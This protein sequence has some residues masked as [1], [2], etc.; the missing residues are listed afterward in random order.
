MAGSLSAHVCI[1]GNLRE[2]WPLAFP[3]P[4]LVLPLPPE[5]AVSTRHRRRSAFPCLPVENFLT[6]RA[7]R[8]PAEK[9][10]AKSYANIRQ[11]RDASRELSS[12][13]K[14]KKK[15]E[16]VSQWRAARRCCLSCVV[17]SHG[18]G[19]SRCS[20]LARCAFA[21][22]ACATMKTNAHVENVK[23]ESQVRRAS[24]VLVPRTTDGCYG[25]VERAV[26]IF[27]SALISPTCIFQRVFE[28]K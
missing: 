13:M 19:K 20:H 2:R 14:K 23:S 6:S 5:G 15:Y 26:T 16:S 18:D 28:R 1:R 22:N 3:S 24:H 11:Q 4:W 21:R 7:R 8:A 25:N 12:Q 17:L 27:A 10:F 9:A